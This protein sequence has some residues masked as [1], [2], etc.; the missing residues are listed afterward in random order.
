MRKPT[1]F[2]ASM[3][4]LGSVAAI[5]ILFLFMTSCTSTSPCPT[6]SGAGKGNV[7]LVHFT[8]KNM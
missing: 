4:L 8:R 1:D 7:K 5:V 6:Y 2:K 3:L